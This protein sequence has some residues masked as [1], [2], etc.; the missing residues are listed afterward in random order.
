[1]LTLREFGRPP[2]SYALGNGLLKVK[3]VIA[4]VKGAQF[5]NGGRKT[6]AEII[7]E[8]RSPGQNSAGGFASGFAITET[9]RE[10]PIIPRSLFA[11]FDCRELD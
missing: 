7:F 10:P 9:R 1:V 8:R 6:S 3:A 2:P 5:G 4:R 11:A